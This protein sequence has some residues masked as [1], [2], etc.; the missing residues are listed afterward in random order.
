MES[1]KFDALP[2]RNSLTITKTCTGDHALFKTLFR[3]M[4]TIW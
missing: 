4:P 1:M 2:I 3:S